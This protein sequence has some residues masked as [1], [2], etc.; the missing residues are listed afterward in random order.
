MNYY[1]RIFCIVKNHSVLYVDLIGTCY[2]I[3]TKPI[4]LLQRHVDIY[5]HKA[6]MGIHN[7]IRKD[8]LVDAEKMGNSTLHGTSFEEEIEIN[9]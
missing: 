2:D 5:R 6:I 1:E 4:P 9:L 7:K 3:L 8:N